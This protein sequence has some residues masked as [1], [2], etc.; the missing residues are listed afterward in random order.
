LN[1]F[2][3]EI[4]AYLTVAAYYRTRDCLSERRRMLVERRQH[5][6]LVPNSAMF[7]SLDDSK[8]G[9]LL[10]VGEGGVAV[11][12]LIPRNLNDV[13]S[14]AFE[15]P[16][17]N[18]HVQAVTEV[19]WVRDSGHLT[20]V[21]FLNVDELSQRHLCHWIGGTFHN[22]GHTADRAAELTGADPADQ[23]SLPVREDPPSLSDEEPAATQNEQPIWTAGE[24]QAPE[25]WEMSTQ[26]A[27]E[28]SVE[29]R[30]SPSADFSPEEEGAAHGA[31]LSEGAFEEKPVFVTRSTYA[32]TGTAARETGAA[33]AEEMSPI[34]MLAPERELGPAEP[35]ILSELR[36]SG[37]S[38]KSRHTIELILAV[39]LLSWA[40]VFL[41]YQM[42]STSV[43]RGNANGAAPEEP[44]LEEP[45]KGI[46]P[47]VQASPALTREAPSTLTLGD[48]GVVL[49][50]GAMK[51]EDNA[52][53]LA[54]ELQKKNLPAFVF[55]HGPDQ[56]YRVAV[57]PFSDEG[58][59]AKVKAN[60]EKQ[61][62]KPILRRWVPE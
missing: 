43:K 57:G 61:G 5:V 45:S 54:Q 38:S 4:K 12:S 60:L 22:G 14:L 42:G 46:V 2:G 51:L 21:R 7:V 33:R 25:P 31:P 16:E 59:T 40:L 8:S 53:V 52:D 1:N 56:L 26:A 34:A 24:E 3:V 39:V 58:A 32:Q 13:I 55:R 50:V 19:A 37:G 44:V 47:S 36:L 41:G 49:Q 27:C 11:A 10:D 15:L 18:G 48:S 29:Q 23:L 62:L 28:E 9:L 6:R 17:G 35:Q 30:E 20:G